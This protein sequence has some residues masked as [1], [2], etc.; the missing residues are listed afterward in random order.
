M[1]KFNFKKISKTITS[2]TLVCMLIL[3][4]IAGVS[5]TENNNAGI[6]NV[7][8]ETVAEELDIT[9]NEAENLEQNLKKAVIQIP[10]LEAG[11]SA[12][13]PVS[14]NLVLQ[15]ETHDDGQTINS[16]ARA[17]HNKTITSTLKLKNILGATIVTLKSVGVFRINGSTSKPID[18]YGTH[19]AVVWNVTA[20]KAVKGSAAY[21][22]YVRNT[23][24][25]KLNV[26]IDPVHM[27]VQSFTYACT[28]HCNAKGV[29]KTSWK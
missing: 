12:N 7:T 29:Y 6:L 24:T 1:K 10:A 20:K 22:A 13:V 26:G 2:F 9:L 19:D 5:A 16:F 8:P 14:E 3:G 21:N 4:H 17:T 28:I 15:V 27:T 11:D 23:F 25:G 18:A